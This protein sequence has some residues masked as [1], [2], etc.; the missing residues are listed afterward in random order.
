LKIPTVPTTPRTIITP[1]QFDAIY[2]ALPDADARLL[3][4]TAIETGLRWGELAEL[5]I[6]DLDLVNRTVTVSRKVIELNQQFHPAGRRFLVKQYPKDKRSTGGSS[7]ARRSPRSSRP[8]SR[9]T[10]L[11]RESSCSHGGRPYRRQSAWSSNR[12]PLA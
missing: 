9:L 12:A 11:V 7:S 3:V 4:E 6:S 8:T 10:A 5:R 1:E 2:A